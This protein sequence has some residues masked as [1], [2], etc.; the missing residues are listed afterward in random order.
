MVSTGGSSP[1]P[2]LEA[3]RPLAHEHLE[4]VDH[5]RAA[6]LGPALE[7]ASR[8]AVDEID[9]DARASTSGSPSSESVGS[10]PDARWRS[11]AAPRARALRRRAPRT[12]RQLGR[13]LGRAV[14]DG[15]LG[16]RLAQRPGRRARRRRP[17]RARAR[18][19]ARGSPSASSS[20]PASVLSP[21]IARRRSKVSVFTAPIA[22]GGVAQLVGQVVRRQLVR[23]RHVGA[24]VAGR[25]Q[26]P[27][28]LVEALGRHRQLRRSASRARAPRTRRSSSP[29][30]GCARPGSRGRRRAAQ[31]VVGDL[32]P[33]S[34]RARLYSFT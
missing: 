13:P 12:R 24:A 6:L 9:H 33:R 31:Q 5:A 34:S 23:D 2:A 22:R 10:Q 30:S 4:P 21:A 14:P 3:A 15:H 7:R 32:P 19:R 26:R 8:G 25:R 27:H 1:G 28:R 20:P 16:A 17:L 11:R 18:S 29:A